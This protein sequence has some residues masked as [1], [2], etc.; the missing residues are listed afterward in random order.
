MPGRSVVREEEY[1]RWYASEELAHME[2]GTYHDRL[3]SW[4][5]D[6]SGMD[7]LDLGAGPGIWGL[8]LRDFGIRSLTWHDRSEVFRT[9][10]GEIHRER[11]FSAVDYRVEDLMTVKYPPNSFDLVVC[12]LSLYY[13]RNEWRLLRDLLPIVRPGGYL[14]IESP[15]LGRV[16]QDP[17][18][19]RS[20]VHIASP[21]MALATRRKLAPTRFQI[22]GF[23]DWR[24][25]HLGFRRCWRDPSAGKKAFRSLWQRPADGT[26]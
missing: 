8:V 10:A 15:K 18:S 4:G 22:E 6:L 21:F 12:R 1:A 14:Y 23:V 13:A 3:R 5:V 24:L 20:P 9:L 25:N 17:L 11:E 2:E 16:L 7:V 26:R 19:F